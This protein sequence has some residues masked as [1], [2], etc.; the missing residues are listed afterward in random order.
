MKQSAELVRQFGGMFPTILEKDNN[1]NAMSF[2]LS[3]NSEFEPSGLD[4]HSIKSL[5]LAQDERWR[6]A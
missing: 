4:K 6:R 2:V 3:K 1:S 5:I